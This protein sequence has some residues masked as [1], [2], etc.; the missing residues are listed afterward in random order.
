MRQAGRRP[1]IPHRQLCGAR[2]GPHLTSSARRT[3]DPGGSVPKLAVA[4][5]FYGAGMSVAG[6]EPPRISPRL[7]NALVADLVVEDLSDEGDELLLRPLHDPMEWTEHFGR[8]LGMHTTYGTGGVHDTLL[9]IL[10]EVEDLIRAW[11]IRHD[12]GLCRALAHEATKHLGPLELYA[13]LLAGP[14]RWRNA[15]IEPGCKID[16]LPGRLQ[17]ILEKALAAELNRV[18]AKW[19]QWDIRKLRERRSAAIQEAKAAQARAGA[20]AAGPRVPYQRP[21]GRD[22]ID[23][24]TPPYQPPGRT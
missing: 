2:S 20:E 13:T 1:G 19:D 17:P 8:Q 21:T 3:A 5:P 6:I 10:R 22:R 15:K 24:L 14:A 4:P 16:R 12:V 11:P 18:L 9:L 7:R 23:R